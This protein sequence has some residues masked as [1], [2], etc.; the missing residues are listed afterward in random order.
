MVTIDYPSNIDILSKTFDEYTITK[1]KYEQ[2]SGISTKDKIQTYETKQYDISYLWKILGN[3][4]EKRNL[5]LGIDVQKS[6]SGNNLYSFNFSISG[7]YVKIIEFIKDLEN[8]SDLY[9]R[10]YDFKVNG[11]GTI[12]NANFRVENIN[13]DPTTIK[14]SQISTTELFN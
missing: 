1:E 7:E 9:F 6:N 3:Y 5:T 8:D 12:L 13:I 4:A 14:N 11:S 10:I 2:L